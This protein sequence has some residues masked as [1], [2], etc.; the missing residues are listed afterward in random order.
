MNCCNIK[1]FGMTQEIFLDN[2]YTKWYF[3]LINS[4]RGRVNCHSSY[5][6]ENHIVPLSLGGTNVVNNLI[7][8]TA[9]GHYLAHLLLTKMTTGQS[10]NENGLCFAQ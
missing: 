7:K 8:L 10:I 1:N 9:R 2:K 4:A 6:E 5:I 3:A